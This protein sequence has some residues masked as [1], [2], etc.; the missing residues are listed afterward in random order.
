MR[1]PDVGDPG[2]PLRVYYNN[3]AAAINAARQLQ[4]HEP[5][6]HVRRPHEH[7]RAY[8]AREFTM[9]ALSVRHTTTHRRRCLPHL[10]GAVQPRRGA[11][12]SYAGRRR[13]THPPSTAPLQGHRGILG[14]R[15][16]RHLHIWGASRRPCRVAST[17]TTV[18]R[19]TRCSRS[20]LTA[21]LRD[22][23]RC[24]RPM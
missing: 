1:S 20:L 13:P 6:H 21:P 10:H 8:G 23:G 9:T 2:C 3:D 7:A 17:C 4:Q 18:T 11:R 19:T 15:S 16:L 12:H 22:T 24:N 14:I 5:P